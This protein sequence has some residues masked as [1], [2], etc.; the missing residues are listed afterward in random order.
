MKNIE[1]NESKSLNPFP[2]ERCGGL[3]RLVGS[4]PHPAE[5]KVDLLTFTCTNCGAFHVSQVEMPTA[6]V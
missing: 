6:E 5:S 1:I 4:E 3:M 2:C